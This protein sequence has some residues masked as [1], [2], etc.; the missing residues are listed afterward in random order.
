LKKSCKNKLKTSGKIE[1]MLED[2]ID[3]VQEFSI[4]KDFR[5]RNSK[6]EGSDV[7]E[8]GITAYGLR[9]IPRVSQKNLMRNKKSC[10]T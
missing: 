2:L 8:D 6:E 9:T 5:K 10:E 7:D 4:E 3:Q 1:E